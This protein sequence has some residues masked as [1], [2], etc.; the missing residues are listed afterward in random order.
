M[1]IV[2]TAKIYGDQQN[3]LFCE[4]YRVVPNNRYD[5]TKL[6]PI[7]YAISASDIPNEF[8]TK[9]TIYYVDTAHNNKL[10]CA[11][12]YED[13]IKQIKFIENDVL[14]VTTQLSD[15]VVIHAVQTS[16]KDLTI[17]ISD[18][19]DVKQDVAKLKNDLILIADRLTALEDIVIP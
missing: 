17:K 18:Y 7:E 13:T 2:S 19:D 8:Y 5:P 15:N 3:R 9:F 11:Y 14:G 1:L 6:L 16:V 12:E 4:S 10:V